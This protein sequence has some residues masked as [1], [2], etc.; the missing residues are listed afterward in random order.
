MATQLPVET[1]RPVAARIA[2]AI[3]HPDLDEID[4]D[5]FSIDTHPN[6][7]GEVVNL[8]RATIVREITH[9]E[10]IA[11]LNGHDLLGRSH[12]VAS[13]PAG[14]RDEYRRQ[15]DANRHVN[16]HGIPPIHPDQVDLWAAD[17]PWLAR[18]VRTKITRNKA[19]IPP[20]ERERHPATI[21]QGEDG[22]EITCRCGGFTY[23]ADEDSAPLAVLTARYEDHLR[24]IVYAGDN[25]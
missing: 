7:D 23:V 11:I 3:Q 12:A 17:I 15:Y 24:T 6:V 18:E 16:T 9:G 25:S 13:A 22:L 14:I 21:S 20:T 1:P 10:A 8:L 2:L 4:A 5:S 19:P